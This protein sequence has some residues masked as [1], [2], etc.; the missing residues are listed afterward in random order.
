MP[1]MIQ[2]TEQQVRDEIAS[3]VEDIK[4]DY[5]S[6]HYDKQT[7]R[8]TLIERM[9]EDCDERLWPHLVKHGLITKYDEDDMVETALASAIIIKVAKADAWVEDDHGL[10]D[11]MTHGVQACIAYYSLRNLMYKALKDAGIDT[12]EERP[13]AK[14]RLKKRK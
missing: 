14:S 3:W 1:E 4:D 13:F 6:D 5:R 10:W 7:N 2:L 11:G 9:D 12:N 8:E